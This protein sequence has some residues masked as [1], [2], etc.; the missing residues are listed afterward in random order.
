MKLA[1]FALCAVAFTYM[2]VMAL[3]YLCDMYERKKQVKQE[4]AEKR[5]KELLRQAFDQAD[6]KRRE[7]IER[8][9]RLAETRRKQSIM[10]GRAPLPK[11]GRSRTTFAAQG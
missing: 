2:Y 10:P 6:V 3:C 7:D 4:E 8:R 1:I 11:D 9:K 5:R